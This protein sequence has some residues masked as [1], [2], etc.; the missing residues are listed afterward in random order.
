MAIQKNEYELSV[1]NEELINGIKK[2]SKGVIIGGHDMTYLG[3]AT[4]LKFTRHIKGTTSL[5]F[6]MPTKFFDSEKGDYVKNELIDSLFNECKI[7]LFYKNQW[8]EY[9]IKQISEEKQFKAIMKT[10]TCQDAFIDE[11]SR[12]GYE[13]EFA[14]ELNNSVEEIGIFSEEI[15]EKSI[16]DYRPENNWGDFTEYREERFY[17]IPLSQ[18]GGT[19]KAYKINLKVLEGEM[20]KNKDI[21]IIE[22]AIT[23]ER[24][25][26]EYGDD[27]A[28]QEEMFWDSYSSKGRK[29]LLN[30]QV[31]LT[32]DYIYVPITDLSFIMGSIY[33]S[34]TEALETPAYYG[35]YTNNS[36]KYALQPTS[37]NPKDFIQFLYFNEDDYV[38]TDEVNTIINMNCHYIIPIEDWS[39]ILQANFNKNKGCIYW[40]SLNRDSELNKKTIYQMT[41]LIN[42]Y[43]YTKNVQPHS[44]LIDK[45]IWYPV[46]YDGYLDMINNEEVGF[47]RKIVISDRTELNVNHDIYTKVYQNHAYEYLGLYSDEELN[48]EVRRRAANNQ[49]N[50][51]V[52]SKL[53]TQQILPSLARDL[54]QNGKNITDATGWESRIQNN[55]DDEILGTGSFQKLL[56][57]SVKTLNEQGKIN[58]LDILKGQ[59]EDEIITDY[60]L[61]FLSPVIDKTDN[62]N[63]EGTVSTDYALNFGIVGQEKEITKGNIYAIRMYTARTEFNEDTEKYE[64]VKEYNVDL[65]RVIIGSG[66][67]NLKGNY[68]VDGIDNND[69][70]FIKMGEIVAAAKRYVPDNTSGNI[71]TTLYHIKDTDEKWS[72]STD[73]PT[74]GT[75]IEDNCFILFRAP[76]TI[77]N[78]YIAIKVESNPLEIKVNNAQQVTYS[79][80]DGHGV[81]INVIASVDSDGNANNNKLTELALGTYKFYGGI[82]IEILEINDQNFSQDFLDRINY[83]KDTGL[84]NP[85]DSD[86]VILNEGDRL[87]G[88]VQST[89]SSIV[90]PVYCTTI[91]GEAG[92][93]KTMANALFINKEFAG[94]FWLEKREEN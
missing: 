53:D 91:G 70:D 26:M 61:E 49:P 35:D 85:G 22:N 46:Y 82:P 25:N 14:P 5:T 21:P 39:K 52:V 75:Y 86:S 83:D 79:L 40:K 15:L 18:F 67:T 11:L 23:H 28:R 65:N 41:G 51:R 38:L 42:G 69:G 9:L 77:K 68:I 72:W 44:S 87:D 93:K 62:F 2:E 81:K 7:K 4:N 13:L 20:G 6:Q 33:E 54:V 59:Y 48:E 90:M 60:Y 76:K 66:S 57:I 58:D 1:W 94:I 89:E 37:Q 19:I 73:K 63:L 78:P 24:R 12:T 36:S 74:S 88:Q 92:D 16:W 47:A 45:F 30:E 32:G 80:N 43:Y 8:Y 84:I 64:L 55:N 17:R 56:D 29:K 34:S 71:S 10:F 31:T 27:L 50:F 3:R